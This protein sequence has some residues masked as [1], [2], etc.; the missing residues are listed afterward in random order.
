MQ[1]FFYKDPIIEGFPNTALES[2]AVGTPVIAFN[3]PGGT[4]EIIE[5]NINGILV[6][7]EKAFLD[8]LEKID[9]LKKIYINKKVQEFTYNKFNKEKILNLY[10]DE[11]KS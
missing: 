10:L 6:N 5:N 4:K 7:S 3:V 9:A 2:C 8:I 1:I 11:F